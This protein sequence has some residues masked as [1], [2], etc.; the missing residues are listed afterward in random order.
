MDDRDLARLASSPLF[1]G[2][3]VVDLAAFLAQRRVQVQS[4]A[5]GAVVLLSGCGY[6]DLR[7]LLEGQ[8]EAEMASGGGR[9]LV[10]ETFSPP[11]AIA[12][13]VLFSPDPILPVTVIAKT[14]LRLA[15]IPKAV[16]LAAAAAFPPV[17]AAL[18]GDMGRRLAVLAEKYRAVSFTTLRERLADWLLRQ[19]GRYPPLVAGGPSRLALRL[20]ESKER[21]SAS[22]GVA[23][24][25]LS[26][27]FAWFE[28]RGLIAMRGRDIDILDEAALERIRDG[29]K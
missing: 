6:E 2:T 5:P 19:A 11:E 17:L 26:R 12:T 29:E 14:E 20:P 7:V 24:P 9:T 22:F 18:L 3:E 23:R 8:A 4:F 28:D 15:S 16:L 21:L 1:A 10:V 13:A 27:E 25:S